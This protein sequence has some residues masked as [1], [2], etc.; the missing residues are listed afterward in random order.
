[1]TVVIKQ[2]C[3]LESI[4]FNICMVGVTHLANRKQADDAICRGIKFNYRFD[5]GVFN[6]QRLKALTKVS[7]TAFRG[8]Q[9]ADDTAIVANNTAE[10]Q[11]EEMLIN[12]AYMRMGLRLYTTRTEVMHRAEV[13]ED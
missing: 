9:Y 12:E 6:L 7:S 3:V 4:I 8:Q 10:V 5:G 1:M 2:G 11:K 13:R